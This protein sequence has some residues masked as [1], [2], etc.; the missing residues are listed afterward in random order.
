MEI[1]AKIKNARLEAKLT[2]EQAAEALCVSRQ[3]ISNWENEKTYPDIVSVIKMSDIY[4]IS[5][6]RLLKEENSM[7]K[8]YIDY[9]E[10]STNT[11]KSKTKLSKLILIV[12]YLVIWA[13]SIA[14]FW[15]FTAESDAMAYGL[16]FI[17]IVNPVA[18]F[19]LSFIV[20]K[21]DYWGRLKWICSIIFGI[22]FS[23]VPY[24]TYDMANMIAFDK[25]IPIPEFSMIPVG[26][27]ISVLG[28]LLGI[29]VEH[30]KVKKE[31]K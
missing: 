18:I 23:L 20:G 26:A 5:L 19:L 10:E 4:N 15:F 2:Q 11:V 17:W 6:D 22:L 14:A 29:A 8:N 16:I 24:T 7:S 28:L 25:P 31:T 13:V 9:L 27:I 1:G 12:S 3:T 21:N 30:I